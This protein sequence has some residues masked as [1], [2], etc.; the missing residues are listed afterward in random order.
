MRRREF[1][2]VIAGS[3]TIW[4]LAAHAQQ[5]YQVRRIGVLMNR[6]AADPEGQ[7]DIAAFRQSLQQLGWGDGGNTR[8]D[9][10][11]AEE[12]VER[13]RQYATELIA[14]KPDIVL[15]SGTLSVGPLQR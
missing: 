13:E 3:A 10:R 7:A 15:A 1:I 4:P 8:I 5:S 11:W 6:G 9:V 12:D 2:K 14:L